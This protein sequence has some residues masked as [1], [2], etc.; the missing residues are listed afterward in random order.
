MQLPPVGGVKNARGAEKAG[1]RVL[2][3]SLNPNL[4]ASFHLKLGAVLAQFR[5][6]V[7][8]GL[9]CAATQAAVPPLR[10]L[11]LPAPLRATPWP[12]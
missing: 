3:V 12:A 9:R 1:P 7:R 5:E 8:F 10:L 6:K 2:Q 4:D 11:L